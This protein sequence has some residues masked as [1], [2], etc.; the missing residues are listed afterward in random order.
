MK[1]RSS[2][3][4]G[5]RTKQVKGEKEGGPEPRGGGGHT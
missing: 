3:K 5:G 4:G 1:G 2:L